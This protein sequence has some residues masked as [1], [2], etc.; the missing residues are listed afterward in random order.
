MVAVSFGCGHGAEPGA[1]GVVA[2]GRV[3]PLCMLIHETHRSRGE[4]L[5]KVAPPQRAAL[6]RET[7]IGAEYEWR[8]SR[9]HDARLA[10]ERSPLR[11][12]HLAQELAA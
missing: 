5:R 12:R 8:C 3:C 2:L 9:G 7:R 4:L 1:A 6:A 10:G 11:R